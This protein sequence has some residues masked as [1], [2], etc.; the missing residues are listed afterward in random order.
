[1]K[2]SRQPT[3][4]TMSDRLQLPNKHDRRI[5][6]NILFSGIGSDIFTIENYI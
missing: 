4:F 1:M 3:F 5:N 6:I 2:Y